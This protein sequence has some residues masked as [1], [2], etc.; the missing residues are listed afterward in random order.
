MKHLFILFIFLV[1]KGESIYSQIAGELDLSFGLSGITLTDFSPNPEDL[2][3][4]DNPYDIG[5]Q[6]DGKI[7]ASGTALTDS[8]RVFAISRYFPTGE[9]D[10]DFGI[11]GKIKLKFGA[12]VSSSNTMFIQSDDKIILA[13][14]AAAT[15]TSLYDFGLIRLNANGNIDSTFGLNGIVLTEMNEKTDEI[16]ALD[17]LDDNSIVAV[18]YKHEGIFDDSDFA[19]CKYSYNGLLD[20][21]F[22]NGGKLIIDL[23]NSEKA[24]SI[25]ANSDGSL[26]IGGYSYYDYYED[27]EYYHISELVLLRLLSSGKIDSTFGINGF[28]ITPVFDYRA[29]LQKMY[30]VEDGKY[31]CAVKLVKDFSADFGIVKFDSL[32]FLDSTFSEDGIVNTDIPYDEFEIVNDIVIQADNKILM[33]GYTDASADNA[34]DVVVVRYLQEGVLDSTF[35]YDGISIIDINELY[36]QGNAMCL[37]PDGKIIVAADASDGE[38]GSDFAIIRLWGDSGLSAS[39]ENYFDNNLTIYPNPT[40]NTFHLVNKLQ[41]LQSNTYAINLYST[42]GFLCLQREIMDNQPVDITQLPSGIY[43]LKITDEFNNITNKKLIKIAEK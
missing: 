4:T 17:I 36:N 8:G 19:I 32:G 6:S 20:T 38:G 43:T 25:I 9:L 34:A 26:L 29:Y 41:Q 7:I 22:G 1:Q 24:S 40:A 18:G 23:G 39:S 11:E 27:G 14:G 37:Q 15:D 2:Y 10:G 30:E 31:I 35:Q 13:G 5:L 3:S 28:T 16:C 12:S 33:V 42:T 21:T